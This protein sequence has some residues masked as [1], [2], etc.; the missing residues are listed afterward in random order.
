MAGFVCFPLVCEVKVLG[1]LLTGLATLAVLS[2]TFGI[3]SPNL[4]EIDIIEGVN[5]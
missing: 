5:N 3:P 2:C 4:D 1:K